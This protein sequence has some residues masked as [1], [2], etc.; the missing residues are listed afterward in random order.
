MTQKI[1]EVVLCLMGIIT[2]VINHPFTLKT[3][4]DLVSLGPLLRVSR[5]TPLIRIFEHINMH[6]CHNLGYPPATSREDLSLEKIVTD[7]L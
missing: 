3:S 2:L 5:Y 4:C 7:L 6:I 1:I